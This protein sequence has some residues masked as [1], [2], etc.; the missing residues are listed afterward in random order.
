VRRDA[1][2]GLLSGGFLLAVIA[3]VLL[4]VVAVPEYAEPARGSSDAPPALALTGASPS[5]SS[6]PQVAL[7]SPTT[8]LPDRLKGYRWPVSGGWVTHYYARDRDGRF[9]IDGERIHGGLAISWFEGALV[10]AAHA[11]RVVAAG[12]DWHEHV[13]YDGDLD[14]YYAR[15][16]RKKARPS[17]GVVIDDGNGYRSVY[18]E[19]KDLRVKPGER[20]KAGAVIGAMGYADE[21]YGQYMV[22]YELVR[23]DGDWLKVSN[24]ARRLGLPDYVREHVDPLAVLRLEAR[25]KPDTDKRRPPTDPP[26]LSEY[27][28]ARGGARAAGQS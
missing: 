4:I 17:L 15:L 25:K 16:K 2:S 19:L 24:Q 6:A 27:G 26:R 18:S 7:P 21:P 13:G 23:T 5:P 22:N 3:A 8:P 14:D 9:V 11:G 28:A 12:R 1:L 20:V 10:K